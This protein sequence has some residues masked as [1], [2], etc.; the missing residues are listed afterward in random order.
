VTALTFIFY[1]LNKGDGYSDKSSKP[2]VSSLELLVRYT[3]TLWS[4]AHQHGVKPRS[5]MPLPSTLMQQTEP[6]LRS[7]DKDSEVR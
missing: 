1:P 3:S 6:S 7:S 5:G 4:F 2:A